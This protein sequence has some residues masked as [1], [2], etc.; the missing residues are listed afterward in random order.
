MGQPIKRRVAP[1]ARA[2]TADDAP[3][4]A[5]ALPFSDQLVPPRFALLNPA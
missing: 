4:G 1:V 5:A 2:L 3:A